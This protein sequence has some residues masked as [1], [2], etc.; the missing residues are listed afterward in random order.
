MC[1]AFVVSGGDEG[2]AE[3]GEAVRWVMATVIGIAG[4]FPP[5]SQEMNGYGHESTSLAIACSRRWKVV[6]DDLEQ[7][8]KWGRVCTGDT[9]GLGVTK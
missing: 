6:D 3:K 9:W 1:L 4:E 7:W 8:I 2:R 5:E